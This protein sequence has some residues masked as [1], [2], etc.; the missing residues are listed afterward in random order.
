MIKFSSTELRTKSVD[1]YNVVHLR[2]IVRIDHRDR[3]EMVL[4]TRDHF[5]LRIRQA[6]EKN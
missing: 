5:E 2:G 6:S 3:P 4:M 1:V